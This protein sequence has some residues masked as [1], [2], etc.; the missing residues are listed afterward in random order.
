MFKK[1]TANTIEFM[2]LDDHAKM[3]PPKPCKM[4]LPDWYKN[5]PIY[6]EG[7]ELTA[8]SMAQ[9]NYPASV[10]TVKKC[11]PVQDFLISGYTIFSNTELLLSPIEGDDDFNDFL[12]S[13]PRANNNLFG[14]HPYR[15]CPVAFNGKRHNYIKIYSNWGIKTP[16][17]YSCLLLQPFYHNEERFTLLPAI[18]DTD[19]YH[20]T[21]GFIGYINHGV[22]NFKLEAGTPIINVY[23]FKRESWK[24]EI[25]DQLYDA[26]RSDFTRIRA[27]FFS[28]VYRKF[29]HSKKRYD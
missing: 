26:D 1:L 27:Q 14:T 10:F 9:K 12:W 13:I 6:I 24:M 28:D 11:L 25:K 5:L 20:D 2:P 15:Q 23:P 19:T 18:V 17:G 3:F 4:V 29:F 8:E 16:P 21:V 22:G 7:L